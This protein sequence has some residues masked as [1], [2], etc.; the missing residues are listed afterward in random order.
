MKSW[1]FSPPM[2]LRGVAFGLLAF[3]GCET[4]DLGT[5]DSTA[6]PPYASSATLRP[7]TVK[8]RTLTPTDGKYTIT[9]LA[10]VRVSSSAQAAEV[11]G[12]TVTLTLPGSATEVVSAALHDDGVAPDST[13]GDL[14]Y[15]G[16]VQ[17]TTTLTQAGAYR[18]RFVLVGKSGLE[19]NLLE[20]ILLVDRDNKAPVIASIIAPDTVELAPDTLKIGMSARA[21]DQD[22]PTDIKEVYFRSLDSSDPNNKFYLLDNGDTRNG[23]AFKGD[24]LYSI[25]IVLPPNPALKKTYRFAFQASDKYGDTSA[26]VVHRMTVR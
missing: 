24:S 11:T 10:Q 13:A 7:D 26:T 9:A 4:S 5:V 12:A 21:I 6:L 17:F 18:A 14:R 16:T 20:R 3:W 25:I 19:S 22:G 15:T 1:T 2:L 8:L 23:D